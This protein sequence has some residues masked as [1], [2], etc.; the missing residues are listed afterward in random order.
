MLQ[1]VSFLANW[2]STQ[3]EATLAS[4]PQLSLF[5]TLLQIKSPAQRVP[6]GS[7]ETLTDQTFRDIW[8]TAAWSTAFFALALAPF[9]LVAFWI[10]LPS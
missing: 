3:V 4:L 8:P 6:I 5:A 2:L 9:I 1:A 10:L 7:L